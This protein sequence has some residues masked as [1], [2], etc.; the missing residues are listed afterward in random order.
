MKDCPKLGSVTA[1]VERTE[2]EA[3]AEMGS[4]RL[5][6]VMKEKFIPKNTK[7]EGLMYVDGKINGK[8]VVIMCDTRATH[9]FIT[10]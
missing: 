6:N 3:N 8:P 2:E 1:M 7:G 4:L 5:L 10:P 9:N